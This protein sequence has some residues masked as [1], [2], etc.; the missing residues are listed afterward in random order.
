MKDLSK[1]Q[2]EFLYE[3]GTRPLHEVMIKN[4]NQNGF[5]WFFGQTWRILILDFSPGCYM[6]TGGTYLPRFYITPE[7]S[8]NEGEY[9]LFKIVS[10]H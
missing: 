7:T 1:S 9:Q 5:R 4:L 2:F 10:F 8:F 3:T 6:Q